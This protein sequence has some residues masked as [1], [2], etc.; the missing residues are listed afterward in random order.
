MPK[1][2]R[3]STKKKV[4]TSLRDK[5][6]NIRPEQKEAMKQIIKIGGEAVKPYV[7]TLKRIFKSTVPKQQPKKRKYKSV[8]DMVDTTTKERQRRIDEAMNY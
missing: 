1:I 7:N 6:G 5:D 2:P 4:D 8:Y 3:L